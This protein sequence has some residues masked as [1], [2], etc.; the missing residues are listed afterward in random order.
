MRSSLA[1]SMPRS[2]PTAPISNLPR[3][4]PSPRV[5]LRASDPPSASTSLLRHLARASERA[6]T[7]ARRRVTRKRAPDAR[8]RR[9][10]NA[11]FGVTRRRAIARGVEPRRM[12]ARPRPPSM[13]AV[14]R[15]RGGDARARDASRT[16]VFRRLLDFVTPAEAPRGGKGAYDAW[17]AGVTSGEV[18][19]CVE[20]VEGTSLEGKTLEIVYDGARD[21]FAARTF[22]ARADD[23]G[24]CVVVGI[25]EGGATFGGFN[26]LGFYGAEDYR[27]TGDA[28]LVKWAS[29]AA[30][31]RG[32]AP[33]A[34]ANVLPGGNAVRRR[35]RGR[36]HV[37]T[38]VFRSRRRRF[39][40]SARKGRVSASTRCAFRSG[41]RR[42]TGPRTRAWGGR[43]ISGRRTPRGIARQSRDWART[44]RGF[45]TG[46]GY[47]P[48]RRAQ[49][50]RFASSTCTPRPN[51]NAKTTASSM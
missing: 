43:T 14:A 32:D 18:L 44:T 40:I 42:R 31:R 4:L 35:D 49:T 21:G 24:P 12:D 13:R 45:P 16:R 50:P 39:L 17:L 6:E 25:T 15:A 30:F 1:S 3:A 2:D 10:E 41:T 9:V 23:R 26:P 51:L 29:E 20:C 8:F 7:I 5:A 33:I 22:H 46:A 48:R 34:R 27:S 11:R 38:D 37:G 19:A 36:V 28:F 47:S